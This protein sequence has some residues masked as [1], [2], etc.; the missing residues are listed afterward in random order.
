MSTHQ[1]LN[2]RNNKRGLAQRVSSVLAGAEGRGEPA[3]ATRV[4][5]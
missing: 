4:G 2:S 1:F 3:V 5:L